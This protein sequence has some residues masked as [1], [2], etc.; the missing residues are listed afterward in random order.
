MLSRIILFLHISFF[1]YLIADTFKAQID[2]RMPKR[3]GLFVS[4]SYTN[5]RDDL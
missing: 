2:M 5:N 4:D 3:I 1:H